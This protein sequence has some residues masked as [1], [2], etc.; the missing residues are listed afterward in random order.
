MPLGAAL[1]AAT[2]GDRL[3]LALRYRHAQFDP[4]AAGVFVRLYRDVLLSG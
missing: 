3:H 1:G 2:H 4:P